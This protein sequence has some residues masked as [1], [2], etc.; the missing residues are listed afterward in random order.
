M[1]WWSIRY[2]RVAKGLLYSWL[3]QLRGYGVRDRV[4]IEGQAPYLAGKGEL[5][6]GSRVSFR[7]LYGRSRLFVRGGA[8][9]ELGDRCF[10]NNGCVIESALEV[11]I[12]DNCMIGDGVQIRD[13]AY[14]QVS[15]GSEPKR[16]PVR[17]GRN[18]WLANGCMIL[19]G[20]E[21]GDHSVVGAGA[22]VSRSVP[23]RS[24]VAGNPA[25]V[26]G[27]V[28]ASDGWIRR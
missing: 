7:S 23:Q 10:I 5:V 21:I 17:I 14:H 20:V 22:V 11:V 12:G 3:W 1:G 19:P 6:L 13:A 4:V 2:R 24:I 16:A 8:R 27:E 28:T 15:E 26:V 25:V 9:L 18:V